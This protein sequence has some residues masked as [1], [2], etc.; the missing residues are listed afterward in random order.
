MG[1]P[2]R[3]VA[4]RGLAHH[5]ELRVDLKEGAQPLSHHVVVVG[6]Q[7]ADRH[8]IP[9]YQSAIRHTC[10]GTGT[11]TL[12]RVPAPGALSIWSVPPTAAARSRIDRSPRCPGNSPCGSNPRPS[13][14][15]TSPT[16]PS[17]T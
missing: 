2:H 17:S 5:L 1:Q 9:C 14:A 3:L 11:R 16:P 12:S 6:D 15:T 13:S 7:D 10:A 8:S 4:V